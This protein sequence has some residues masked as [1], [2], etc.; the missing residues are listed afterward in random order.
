MEGGSAG[1]GG[2]VGCGRGEGGG[3]GGKCSGGDGRDGRAERRVGHGRRG[4]G[5]VSVSDIHSIFRVHVVGLLSFVS[6]KNISSCYIHWSGITNGFC[7]QTK[8]LGD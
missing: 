7:Q 4:G 5:E 3:G 1:C 6:V 2:G 8:I